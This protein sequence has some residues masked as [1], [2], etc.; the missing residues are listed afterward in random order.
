MDGIDPRHTVTVYVAAP[1]TPWQQDGETSAAG[2]VYYA[3][4]DGTNIDSYGFAPQGH[5]ASHGPGKVVRTDVND[6]KDPFYSRTMEISKDQYD[7]LREFGN[8][9]DKHGFDME[10]HG[11]INSCI[12]FT[13][14]ALD[15][16]DLHR[17]T[18]FGIGDKSFEGELKPLDNVNAIKSIPAPFPDSDLNTERQNPMPKRT[19]GQWLISTTEQ[20]DQAPGRDQAV[21]TLADGGRQQDL[22]HSQA[23]AAVRRLE[24]GRGQD[25]DA[26]SACLAASMACLAKENGLTRIDHIVLSRAS[27]QVKAGENVFVVQG[28]LDDPARLSAWMKTEQALAVPAGQSLQRLQSMEEPARQ[29]LLPQPEQTMA[30]QH[31]LT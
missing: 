9:P 3:V 7:K 19:L 24:Q 15:H 1:G 22:L 10:Y 23:E 31:R 18:P 4:S 27:G 8:H 11:A 25:Y 5:S 29:P 21:S 20:P 17:E 6:Y 13:W 12:D 2:H 30:P 28:G 14:K 16:A 26:N